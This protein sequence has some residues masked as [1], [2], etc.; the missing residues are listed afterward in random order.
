MSERNHMDKQRTP[1]TILSEIAAIATM[2]RGKLSQMRS[3]SGRVYH[4]L[5]FWSGGRNRCKYVSRAELEIVRDAVAN[6]ERFTELTEE[7]AAAV[8]RRTRCARRAGDGA[9]K[10]SRKRSQTPRGKR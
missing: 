1:E 2:V 7:Y 9:K 10:N 6:Y 5:Q 4:N 3:K 8:E